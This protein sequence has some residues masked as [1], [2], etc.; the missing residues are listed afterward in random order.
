MFYFFGCCIFLISIFSLNQ[1]IGENSLTAD[2][3]QPARYVSKNAG[4]SIQFPPT[5]EIVTGAMGTDV[6]ALAPASDPSD[7]FR[8]S[9]NVIFAKISQNLTR[10][11]YYSFNL[12]SLERLLSDFDL[13]G[14]REAMIG[15]L[16][17]RELIFTH[18]M[19][20]VNVKVMQ[21]L[22]LSKGKGYVI[23]FTANRADFEKYVKTFK[24]I[25][26]SLRFEV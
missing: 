7:L 26:E 2:I 13:E 8:K 11:E 17:A 20:V 4:Y 3:I 16:E 9:V 12:K 6:I 15:G 5:W 14:S 21:Y 23:T 18:T 19:G 22:V 25:A 10:E 1:L 24:Q